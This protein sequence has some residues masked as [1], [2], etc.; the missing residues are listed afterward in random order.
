MNQPH[1][2]PQL[3]QFISSKLKNLDIEF[4]PQVW[5]EM[6]DSLGTQRKSTTIPKLNPRYVIVSVAIVVIGTGLF[7]IIKGIANQNNNEEQ[8]IL[9][10]SDSVQALK[11]D[12][13]KVIEPVISLAP[14]SSIKDTLKKS[15]ASA[16]TAAKFS[17]FPE[18]TIVQNN[19]DKLLTEKKSAVVKE[20]PKVEKKKTKT[21]SLAPTV[22]D[23]G[24]VPEIILPPDTANKVSERKVE[25]VLP[26]SDT[27]KTKNSSLRK[28]GK[29]GKQKPPIVEQPKTEVAPAEAKPDS[30]R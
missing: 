23:T 9:V 17:A 8:N 28:S 29:K 11:P 22:S 12:S 5:L 4:E 10:D 25:T 3:D 16:D 26:A 2:N 14:D 1:N 19:S 21:S 6:E 13:S 18:T 15:M 20:I 27:G 24:F 7:F 30:L